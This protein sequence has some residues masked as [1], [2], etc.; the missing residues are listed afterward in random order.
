MYQTGFLGCLLFP[1]RT[2]GLSKS[3]DSRILTSL[4]ALCLWYVSCLFKIWVQKLNLDLP[5]I[6]GKRDGVGMLDNYMSVWCH[7]ESQADSSSGAYSIL[8][9]ASKS[10]ILLSVDINTANGIL[11]KVCYPVET[12]D[13]P[14]Y[15]SSSDSW[16]GISR[17]AQWLGVWSLQLGG[18]GLNP[19]SD[20]FLSNSGQVTHLSRS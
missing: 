9:N 13:A 10:H 14:S 19:N 4:F 7:L 17:I 20:T 12:T 16:K 15:R 18:L 8:C 1:M 11:R 2:C 3:K 6:D 5:A